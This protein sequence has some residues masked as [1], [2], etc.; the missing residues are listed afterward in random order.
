MR[1]ITYTALL[2]FTSLCS[3]AAPRTSSATIEGTLVSPHT[4]LTSTPLGD[5]GAFVQ[6]MALRANYPAAIRTDEGDLVYVVFPGERLA[7]HVTRRVRASGVLSECGSFIAPDTLQAR[8][9]SGWVEAVAEKA[10]R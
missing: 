7:E 1:T 10:K 8:A 9:E 2:L 6:F 4:Q 3:C 5:E